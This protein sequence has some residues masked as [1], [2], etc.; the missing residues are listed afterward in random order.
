MNPPAPYPPMSQQPVKETFLSKFAFSAKGCLTCLKEAPVE[1]VA[2]LVAAAVVRIFSP[3]L[4]APLLGVGVSMLATTLVLKAVSLYNP[5]LTI[6][7]TKEV[8]IFNNKHPKLQLVTAI[9]SFVVSFVS[10][11]LG[12]ISGG[13]LGGVGCIVLDL[14]R[15]KL[16]QKASR[17][18]TQTVY[19]V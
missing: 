15:Y 9:F 5:A 2:F 18:N 1:A 4:A 10:R 12:F 11:S 17:E 8:C 13:F 3:S 14:E 7:L 6:K 16:M 19:E